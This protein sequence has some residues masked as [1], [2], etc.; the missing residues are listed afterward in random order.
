MDPPA[1]TIS[2]NNFLRKSISDLKIAFPKH[3]STPPYSVPIILGLN[4][5]SGA[6]KHSGPILINLPKDY[7]Y[8]NLLNDLTPCYKNQSEFLKQNLQINYDHDLLNSKIIC[9]TV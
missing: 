2:L 1:N 5:I 9:N 8:D 6:R 3:W 4:N 7:K